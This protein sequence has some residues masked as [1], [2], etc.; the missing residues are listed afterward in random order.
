[1]VGTRMVSITEWVINRGVHPSEVLRLILY[2]FPGIILFALPAASL[3]A[4][5]IAFL[6]LSSD[7]EIIALKSSGISLYQMLPPV[8]VLSFIGYLMASF[9]AVF[10]VPWGNRSFKDLIFQMAQSRA[11]AGIKER[12]FCEPFDDVIF[13]INSISPDERIMK[14]VFVID[15]RDSSMA[16]TIVAREGKVLSNRGSRRIIVHFKDGTIFMFGKDFQS[17]KTLKFATYDLNIYMKD[18]MSALASRKKAPKEMYIQELLHNLGKTSKGESKYNEMM[19]ELMERFSIPLAVFFMGIIGV[20]LGSHVR[21]RA[22]SFGIAV[23]LAIFLIFYMCFMGLRSLCETGF[24]S[25]SIGMWLPDIFLLACSV[26]LFRQSARERPFLFFPGTFN[27][28]E[29][30]GPKISALIQGSRLRAGKY[31]SRSDPV[32]DKGYSPSGH[33]VNNKPE[34]ITGTGNYIGNIRLHRFHNSECKW[35]KKI[36]PTNRLLL[37]S[38]EDA[39][40]QKYKPCT[41]CKP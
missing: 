24:L 6:R 12:I 29:F 32:S 33:S 13:Y 34:I 26:Y 19:I 3:M 9:I 16:S 41:V 11:D 35:A 8:L 10:G 27:V 28:K 15:R 17:I 40:N 22:F 21:S 23:S 4:S 18:I 31:E 5:L 20:P 2:I 30:M 38:R 7:N 39:L 37:R 36:A 1:M 25:P 14:D